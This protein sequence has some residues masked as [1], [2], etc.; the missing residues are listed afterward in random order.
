MKDD[1]AEGPDDGETID[2]IMREQYWIAKEPKDF[3]SDALA[4]FDVHWQRYQTSG[5]GETVARS[6]RMYHSMDPAG[7]SEGYNIPSHAVGFLGEQG[8]FTYAEVN[9]YRNHIQYQKSLVMAER[10]AFVV[11]ASTSE[12]DSLEQVE[13]A[14]AVLDYAMETRGVADAFDR[15]AEAAL[16]ESV[17]W[18]RL[19]WD[20]FGEDLVCHPLGIFDVAY[21]QSRRIEDAEWV[22]ARI[23]ESKWKLVAQAKRSGDDELAKEIAKQTNVDGEDDRRAWPQSAPVSET[24]VDEEVIFTYH[25][26]CRPTPQIPEGRYAVLVNDLVV[27]DGPFRFREIPVY[28]IA[29]NLFLGTTVPYSNSWDL[30]P[31]QQLRNATLSAMASRIDA[32]GVPNIAY[33]EGTDVGVDQNGLTLWP[34]PPGATPPQVLDF[35]GN[36][37]SALPTFEQLMEGMMD[38]IS[39]INSVVRGQPAENISSGSMAALVEAQA[40]KFNGPLERAL[41][42]AMERVGLGIIRMYQAFAPDDMI[43]SITGENE[44]PVIKTFAAG[45]LEKIARVSVQR[46]NPV[47]KTNAGRIEM[48]NN[49]LAQGM[50]KHKTEYMALAKTGNTRSLFADDV[51]LLA[52]VTDENSRMLSGEP[53]K[54]AQEEN[55]L[56]HLQE[57]IARLDSRTRT[58]NPEA[59][60]LLAQH[61]L[62]HFAMYQQISMTTPGMLV[63]HGI[64]PLPPPVQAQM[65]MQAMGA[66]QQAQQAPEGGDKPPRD[67]KAGARGPEPDPKVKGTDPESGTRMPS[68]PKPAEPPKPKG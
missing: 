10:P 24:Q 21:Q 7:Y 57:H 52:H 20:E 41:V 58:R 61:I 65:M 31:L 55:H 44:M 34:F 14:E 56:F 48:A 49:L 66:Q 19:D 3:A 59:A 25:V 42:Y 45:A 64:P 6:Y 26:Y 51:D 39:G 53:V 43:I 12:A 38:T 11:H 5:V 68:M 15:G 47:T 30:M 23:P 37:P 33:Q 35:L 50:L 18:I 22:I 63:P 28:P 27:E 29:P 2:D 1:F 32:F 8:E 13:L 36:F 54:A 60:Q 9:H 16:V 17:G 4:R 40:I 67:P 62:E 46:T